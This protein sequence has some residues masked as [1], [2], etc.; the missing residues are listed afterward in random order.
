MWREH[1]RAPRAAV[2]VVVRHAVVVVVATV[3]VTAAVAVED[4]MPGVAQGQTAAHQSPLEVGLGLVHTKLDPRVTPVV[5]FVTIIF[6]RIHFTA[7]LHT[8]G[9]A[10]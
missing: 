9:P 2:A 7:G 6:Q 8:L 4:G 3:V 1:Q 10:V 5:H